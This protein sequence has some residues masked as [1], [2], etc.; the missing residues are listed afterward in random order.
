MR[1]ISYPNCQL[2]IGLTASFYLI[3]LFEL[4]GEADQPL[5]Q[6]F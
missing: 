5:S 6:E 3:Y 2:T 1:V 4:G